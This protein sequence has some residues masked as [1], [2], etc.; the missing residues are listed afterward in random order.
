MAQRLESLETPG[1][2]EH[3]S[4][5]EVSVHYDYDRWVCSWQNSLDKQS[6]AEIFLRVESIS[7]IY[8]T[9]DKLKWVGKQCTDNTVLL[10]QQISQSAGS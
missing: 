2:D 6:N 7:F 10:F 9:R 3:K 5:A 8:K 1:L 4:T